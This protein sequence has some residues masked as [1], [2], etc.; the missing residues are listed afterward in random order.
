MNGDIQTGGVPLNLRVTDPVLWLEYNDRH[1]DMHSAVA[2]LLRDNRVAEAVNCLQ[3]YIG[4][5][6]PIRAQVD[7]WGGSWKWAVT[8]LSTGSVEGV[9]VTLGLLATNESTKRG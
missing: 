6:A 8:A 1:P 9:R 4:R 5:T 3:T 7:G 2:I